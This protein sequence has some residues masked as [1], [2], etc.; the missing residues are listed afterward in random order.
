MGVALGLT[1]ALI[2]TPTPAFGVSALIALGSICRCATSRTSASH[3]FAS[4]QAPSSAYPRHRPMPH[5]TANGVSQPV[6]PPEYR[7]FV[8]GS[9]RTRAPT[10]IP[11]MNVA[12]R[13]PPAKLKSQIQRS[14]CVL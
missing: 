7:P 8:N 4:Q 14:R 5:R 3:F 12:I 10:V 9:P 6:S 1:F 2:L 11:W 13:K